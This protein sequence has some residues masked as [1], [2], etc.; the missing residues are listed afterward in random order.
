MTNWVSSGGGWCN[1]RTGI[2]ELFL[3]SETESMSSDNEEGRL[4]R[5]NSNSSNRMW[6]SDDSGTDQD[7][8]LKIK[9]PLGKLYC[10]YF[11]Y[12]SPHQRLPF[13]DMV[14]DMPGS[15]DSGFFFKSVSEP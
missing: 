15:C 9:K 3:E 5:T 11:D 2:E 6:D 7:V 1:L 12:S 4:S 10:Q 13:R 8:E 14:I